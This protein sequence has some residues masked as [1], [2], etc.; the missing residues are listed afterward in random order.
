MNTTPQ[1]TNKVTVDFRG[2]GLEALGWGLL[3]VLLSYLII[4]AAWGAVSLYRWMARSLH[5]SDGTQVTF[6]GRASAVWGW[7]AGAMVV[8]ILPTVASMA[9]DSDKSFVISIGLG[10][11]LLP[12]SAGIWWRIVCWAVSQVQ[13]SCGTTLTFKG[14]YK[15][16]LGWTLLVVISVYTIVGWAWAGV[17]MFRWLCQNVEGGRNRV[18]FTGSGLQFLWRAL[19]V[20]VTSLFLIPI[21]WM[22]VW[23]MKWF[24]QNLV[25]EKAIA[26]DATGM[27]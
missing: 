6:A 26:E 12:I 22:V 13:L 17:A 11:L 5:L 25:I 3:M 15:A 9:A 19:L 4:P 14:R 8:A 10:L 24:A 2:T 1:P 16:Y 27:A 20:A 21:P 7:F 18:M 23:L